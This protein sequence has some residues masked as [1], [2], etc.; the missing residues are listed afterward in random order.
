[1]YKLN[2]KE[3]EILPLYWKFINIFKDLSNPY[4]YRRIIIK[5]IRRSYTSEDF[6]NYE[7]ILNKLLW[8][9]LKVLNFKVSDLKIKDDQK[10]F[11]TNNYF[12]RSYSHK[13]V[14]YDEKNK[15]KYLFINYA[16]LVDYEII[17]KICTV[18]L[19]NKLYEKV[20]NDPKYI[21]SI[22]YNN[23][24]YPLDYAFPNVN[25]LFYN[26]NSKLSWIEN[27]NNLYFYKKGNNVNNKWYD[28]TS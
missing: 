10:L 9:L 4:E 2:K 16:K 1:M 3:K 20:I 11:Y 22:K 27:I 19:D 24:Y 8:N 17:N 15:I 26:K 21:N 12:E 23:F 5:K 13:L 28:F 14:L 6:Y 18:L 7:R 25:L